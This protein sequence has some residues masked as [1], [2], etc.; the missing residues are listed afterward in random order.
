MSKANCDSCPLQGNVRVPTSNLGAKIA[1]VGEAPGYTEVAQGIPFVGQSGQLLRAVVDVSDIMLTNV[2]LCKSDGPPCAKAIEC[3]APRLKAELA[4]VDSIL[5]LGGTAAQVLT[6]KKIKITKDHGK[7]YDNVTI[8]YHPAY[9]LRVPRYLDEFRVDLYRWQNPVEV[10]D[11][12]VNIVTDINELYNYLLGKVKVVFDLETEGLHP[13]FGGSILCMSFT[14]EPGISYVVP[15][16]ILYDN[17]DKLS[18]LFELETTWIGHNLAFDIR[19]LQSIGV[20]TP[21]SWVDTLLLHY[22]LNEQK[23]V[24]GLKQVARKLLGCDDWDGEAVTVFKAMSKHI[25]KYGYANLPNIFSLISE[26]SLHRYNAI[27]TDMTCQI[28]DILADACTGQGTI[29]HYNLI[30][31]PS[32]RMYSEVERQGILIDTN[33]LEELKLDYTSQMVEARSDLVQITEPKEQPIKLGEDIGGM[34]GLLDELIKQLFEDKFNPNSPKQVGDYLYGKL[35]LPV[36]KRT[37]KGAPSCDVETMQELAARYPSIEFFEPYFRFKQLSKVIGTYLNGIERDLDENYRV[38]PPFMLHGTVSGRLTAGL[39]LTLPKAFVNP[40]A[41]PLRKLFIA[42]PGHVIACVDYSQA[43]LRVATCEAQE[44]LWQEVFL[45]GGDLHSD[46]AAKF[47]GSDFTDKQRKFIKTIN[48]GLLYGMGAGALAQRLG[49]TIAEAQGV[50]REYY[51][52]IPGV[53]D[54]KHAQERHALQHGYVVAPFGQRRRFNSMELRNNYED[55]MRQAVNFIIQN[56]SNSLSMAAAVEMFNRGYRVLL[57]MHD[58]VMLQIPEDQIDSAKDECLEI[59]EM[60]P[61]KIYGDYVP[62]IGDFSYG[63]GWGEC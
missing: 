12:K 15:Q 17:I 3:C 5:A 20:K 28:H 22:M 7:Q 25:K 55:C 31:Q 44:P 32:Q 42:D 45:S 63:G 51:D 6:G 21:T 61:L 11:T 40:Y 57:T 9:I 1:V 48:F 18:K 27:D 58:E 50:M 35:D 62:F 30:L 47:F 39:Y 53:I 34:R 29:E 56:G 41:E 4:N 33:L 10:T 2:V 43:E 24:Q 23:G 52:M 13:W 46:M 26:D 49:V 60:L 37:A 8:T 54:W 14:A 38:H 16:D 36:L 59:M 19:W